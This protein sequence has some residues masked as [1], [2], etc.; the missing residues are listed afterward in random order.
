MRGARAAPPRLAIWTGAIVVALVVGG[1]FW[2][3]TGKKTAHVPSGI[4]GVRLG[5]GLSEA[6]RALPGL[7]DAPYRARTRV[8]DE[9]ASCTL[10]LG[11]GSTVSRIECVLDDARVRAKLLATLRELYGEETEAREDAWSWRN[12]RARLELSTSPSLR[13]TSWSHAHEAAKAPPGDH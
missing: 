7:T 4:A 5:D 12:E 9:P 13:L 2:K 11:A 1:L 6:R 3:L 10:E 8:F